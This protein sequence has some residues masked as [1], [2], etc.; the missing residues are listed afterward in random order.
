MVLATS[1][2]AG[3]GAITF[4]AAGGQTLQIDAA[5]LA[6]GALANTI[7]GW[8]IGDTIDL[9][10]VGTETQIALSVGNMLVL[11]GSAESVTLQFGPVQSFAGEVIRLISGGAGRTDVALDAPPV[12]TPGAGGTFTGGGPAVSVD[13]SIT[14]TDAGNSFLASATVA[15][16]GGLEDGDVLSF[17]NT[18]TAAF[19]NI[20][21]TGYNAATG[22]LTL[23]SSGAAAT[24][25]QW[26]AALQSVS[27]SFDPSNADPTDGG[28]DTSRTVTWRGTVN[29]T[30]PSPVIG[31]EGV[32]PPR[33]NVGPCESCR[34]KSASLPPL[35]W[36]GHVPYMPGTRSTGTW[37]RVRDQIM[38]VR[39]VSRLRCAKRPVA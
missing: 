28:I 8:A 6:S 27:Y 14:L 2:A 13:S 21:T 10:G 7:D 9:Q 12:V 18:S 5:V 24:L 16:T 20:Q 19:G 29:F 1:G 36:Q 25:A 32:R 38:K 39:L 4:G 23:S 26:Q 3:C 17:A 31:A 37:R 30:V 35:V 34:D 11:S 15:I 22:V 33:S